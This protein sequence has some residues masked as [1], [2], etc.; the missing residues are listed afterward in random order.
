M[1]GDG[2]GAGLPAQR[3]RRFRPADDA[4]TLPGTARLFICRKATSRE[5]FPVIH[6]VGLTNALS[7]LSF[8]A[9]VPSLVPAGRLPSALSLNSTRFNLSRRAGPALAVVLLTTVDAAA[10]YATNTL[11]YI[12]FL[13][14]VMWILPRQAVTSTGD[15]TRGGTFPAQRRQEPIAKGREQKPGRMNI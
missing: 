14:V 8:Q 11:S 7:M 9:I 2:R 1:R 6:V 5:F 10:C 4:F 15:A 13:L 12:P 3:T